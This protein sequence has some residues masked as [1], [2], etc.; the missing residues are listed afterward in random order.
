M[1][2]SGNMDE[3]QNHNFL[4]SSPLLLPLSY[5]LSTSQIQKAC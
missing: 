1:H 3:I 2:K 4:N 5:T